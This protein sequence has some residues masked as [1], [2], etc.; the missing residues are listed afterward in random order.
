[1]MIGFARQIG[2]TVSEIFLQ[3]AAMSI[4][5]KIARGT[6]GSI[7]ICWKIHACERRGKSGLQLLS[8]E[9][10]P[11][12]SYIFQY[13]WCPRITLLAQLKLTGRQICVLEI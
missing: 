10:Y 11:T 6:L 5:L 1:M 9:I 3:T 12:S 2:G 7:C 13:I 8:T 4:V